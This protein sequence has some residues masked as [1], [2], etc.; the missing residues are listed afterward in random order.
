MWSIARGA[1]STPACITLQQL[2][3][4]EA[5]LRH[6]ANAHAAEIR[7]ILNAENTAELLVAVLLPLRDQ[8]RVSEFLPQQEIVQLPR[9]FLFYV[10]QIVN[11]ARALVIDHE[12]FPGGLDLA[13]ADVGLLLGVSHLLLEFGEF[14]FDV[15]EAGWGFFGSGCLDFGHYYLAWDWLC[16]DLA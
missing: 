1:A 3:T 4:L 12:Y 10:I 14:G 7:A 15:R 16:R 6:S 13:L 9:N 8:I 11:E 2:I 5:G